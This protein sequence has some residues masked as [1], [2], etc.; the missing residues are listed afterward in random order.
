MGNPV[1]I[2][3]DANGRRYADALSILLGDRETDAI[4]VL[5][6]PT[7]LADPEDCARATIGV[8]QKNTAGFENASPALLTSWL[9]EQS[10]A[11]ARGLFAHAGVPTF[12]TPDSAVL[13]YMHRVQYRRNQQLLLEVPAA[14]TD[15]FN[16]DTTRAR[17]AI[18]RAIQEN[19][20]WLE[21]D[22][23]GEVLGAYGIPFAGP[24]LAADPDTAAQAAARLAAPVAL[25][26]RS[27]NI[28]HKSDVGG[29]VLNLT[30][31]IVSARKP[32]PC[33]RA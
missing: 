13:G 16:P 4:L 17:V 10:A 2:I 15:N 9:G 24:I 7:A 26:I 22:E 11:A 18:N 12:T 23:L 21:A 19:R 14:R 28:T 3:G 30:N 25:K 8:F 5:N 6:C 29:V 31:R 27:P 1:D 32:S 20:A 33:L